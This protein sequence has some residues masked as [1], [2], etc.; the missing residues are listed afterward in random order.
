MR[1]GHT[2]FHAL[3]KSPPKEKRH[4][5]EEKSE[6][7][8][9]SEKSVWDKSLKKSRRS[10]CPGSPLCFVYVRSQQTDKKRR[11][12]RPTEF[13][14]LLSVG[15]PRE[16]TNGMRRTGERVSFGP[17][18]GSGGG[19]GMGPNEFSFEWPS[20]GRRERRVKTVGVL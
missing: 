3:G 6:K 12:S 20:P 2:F 4:E 10:T 15:G 13:L 5:T 14:D 9:R 18:N 19:G 8:R 16:Q 17:A 1:S 7:K 11:A